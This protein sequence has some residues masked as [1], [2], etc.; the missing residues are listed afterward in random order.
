LNKS[1][2]KIGGLSDERLD[3]FVK[4][5]DQLRLLV[6]NEISLVGSQM[7]AMVG[8]KLRTIMQAHNDSMGGLDVSVTS[9]LYQ[10][11]PVCDA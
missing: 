4:K 2:L 9:N 3:S 8:R 6:I 10:A 5:H 11:P 7:F 1:L